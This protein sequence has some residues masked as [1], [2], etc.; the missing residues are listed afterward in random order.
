MHFDH[1]RA[2]LATFVAAAALP[3]LG[4]EQARALVQLL[5]K[6]LGTGKRR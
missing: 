4:L 2:G 1:M 5:E 6:V 3:R